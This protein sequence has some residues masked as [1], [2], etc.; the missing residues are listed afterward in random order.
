MLNK[1]LLHFFNVYP[2]SEMNLVGLPTYAESERTSRLFLE[3]LF[4]GLTGRGCVSFCILF[5]V[6]SVS[7]DTRKTFP[8]KHKK[9]DLP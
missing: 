3:T 5:I 8:P 1:C 2:T 4:Y 6:K 7:V 9:E